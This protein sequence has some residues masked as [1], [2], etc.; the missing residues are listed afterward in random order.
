[1][2]TFALDT[3]IISYLLNDDESVFTRYRQEI[4]NGSEFV[5]PPVAYYEIKRGLITRNAVAKMRL[6]ECFC[7]EFNI[8]RM[9]T[10]AWDEAARIYARYRKQGQ[11]IDDADLF[12]A[13]FCI[14]NESVLVTN[15]TK[16]FEMIE[17][18]Q[19]TNWK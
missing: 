8:G 7:R 12:I 2:N 15:N 1:M 4:R 19:Y 14:T 9:D 3:N 17:G 10:A 13:A 6:F 18:L 11:M 16:H 5:I